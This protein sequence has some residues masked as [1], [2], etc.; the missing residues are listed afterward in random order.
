MAASW[1]RQNLLRGWRRYSSDQRGA[2]AVEFA[3]VLTLLTIPVLNVI[4][5]ALYAWD[6]M[7]VDNA[8]QMAAQ[9]GWAVCNQASNLPA[10]PNSYANCPNMLTEVTTAVQSTS[11]GAAVTVTA[12]TEAYYCVVSGT[13]TQVAAVTSTKPAN[14]SGFGGLASDVPGDYVQ[15]TA[16][17]TY[18][19][20]FPAMSIV[21]LL[22]TP[23]T[24]IAWTRM[25]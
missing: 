3:I 13:L 14:C 7:Q 2:A 21:S 4:D 10:T 17:Y 18:T 16:S 8:A 5:L 12:T 23:I 24:R 20:I 6:R 25:G 11:L 9:A 1:T 22:A 19:P 15:I